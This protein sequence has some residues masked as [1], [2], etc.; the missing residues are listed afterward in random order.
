MHRYLNLKNPFNSHVEIKHYAFL[1]YNRITIIR[2]FVCDFFVTK[3]TGWVGLLG[4]S[5]L[6]VISGHKFDVFEWIFFKGFNFFLLIG[7]LMKSEKNEKMYGSIFGKIDYYF[8]LLLRK[9][10]RDGD[11]KFVSNIN[12][13]S[14]FVHLI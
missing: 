3:Y 2:L 10:Y 6:R 12:R 7:K 13:F 14:Y 9:K 1:K 5:T 11:L 8:S 4:S